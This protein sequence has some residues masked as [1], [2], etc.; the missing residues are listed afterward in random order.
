MYR[1]RIFAYCSKRSFGA[2]IF[3]KFVFPS[4]EFCKT[5]LDSTTTAATAN[6]TLAYF[7]G[8]FFFR[9]I[10]QMSFPYKLVGPYLNQLMLA[11]FGVRGFK[12]YSYVAYQ[13]Y[14]HLIS[15]TVLVEG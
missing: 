2:E 10:M 6:T 13:N 15:D 5:I 8:P 9:P 11:I 4:A 1:L 12:N 14:V 7:I 3:R